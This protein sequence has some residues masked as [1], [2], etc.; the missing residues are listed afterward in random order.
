MRSAGKAI[1]WEI[2]RLKLAEFENRTP[3]QDSHSLLNLHRSNQ[4][5]AFRLETWKAIIYLFLDLC[6]E[7]TCLPILSR[8]YG[9]ESSERQVEDQRA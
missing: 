1:H 3:N 4:L 8:N 5:R 9:S 2:G 6:R 7:V